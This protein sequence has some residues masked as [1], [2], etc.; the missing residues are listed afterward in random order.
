MAGNFQ[1]ETIQSKAFWDC[2]GIVCIIPTLPRLPQVPHHLETIPPYTLTRT[3]PIE[4]Q[5]AVLSHTPLSPAGTIEGGHTIVSA[6]K[7]Q[8]GKK[9]SLTY[10]KI[11]HIQLWGNIR[12]L[13]WSML[14]LLACGKRSASA[15]AGS[16]VD[17]GH[18]CAVNAESSRSLK[19][20]RGESNSQT[21]C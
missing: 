11:G 5:W 3:T 12:L 19:T 13:S 9:K 15:Y 16:A 4:S 17:Q 21:L 1:A 6:W 20:L 2:R 7:K 10:C 18:T 8:K 14:S